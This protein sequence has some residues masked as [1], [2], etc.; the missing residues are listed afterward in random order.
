MPQPIGIGELARELDFAL[1]QVDGERLRSKE[2]LLDALAQEMDF[3]DYFGRNWDALLDCMR[4]LSWRRSPGYLLLF[5]HA[6]ELL[7]SSPS[8]FTTF[9]EIAHQASNDW[10][11]EGVPFHLVFTGSR[12]VAETLTALPDVEV[13]ICPLSGTVSGR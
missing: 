6:D 3:P 8:D 10:R 13:C 4:D 11:S 12:T 1:F 9:I 7:T 2:A 5:E